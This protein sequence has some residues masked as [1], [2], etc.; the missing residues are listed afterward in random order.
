MSCGNIKY[1]LLL[2]GHGCC[3][4]CCSSDDTQLWSELRF[5]FSL[6]SHSL[7]LRVY[8]CCP[9]GDVAFIAYDGEW[10]KQERIR[11]NNK[12]QRQHTQHEWVFSFCRWCHPPKP[13]RRSTRRG[14]KILFFFFFQIS[15]YNDPKPTNQP[16]NTTQREKDESS[17]THTH[18]T[19][20]EW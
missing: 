13:P 9:L 14:H 8:R 6:L 18:T 10:K 15:T 11:I 7:L 4:C 17:N 5:V 1:L 19:R 12:I 2:I 16:T 20:S 3:Y